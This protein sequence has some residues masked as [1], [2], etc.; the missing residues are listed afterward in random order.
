[1]R[2]P[3]KENVNEKLRDF[4]RVFFPSPREKSHVKSHKRKDD[5]VKIHEIDYNRQFIK[6]A[7]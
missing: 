6:Q 1:M 7:K 5:Q 2:L 4:K 3:R